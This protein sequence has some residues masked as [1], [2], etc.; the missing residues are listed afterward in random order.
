M[1]HRRGLVRFTAGRAQAAVH[2][3]ST[4]GRL[5]LLAA[6]AGVAPEQLLRDA[7]ALDGGSWPPGNS[8]TRALMES[9]AF[10]LLLLRI[11]LAQ[12]PRRIPDALIRNDQDDQV[13]YW[14]DSWHVEFASVKDRHDQINRF[15]EEGQAL[16]HALLA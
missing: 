5:R 14:A 12:L 10:A 8:V 3:A 9:D 13:T 2:H 7:Q 4:H 16:E 15:A 6:T 11:A 1:G